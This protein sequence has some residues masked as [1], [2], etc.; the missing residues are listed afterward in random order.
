MAAL[1]P[2]EQ[3]AMAAAKNPNTKTDIGAQTGVDAGALDVK[4]GGALSGQAGGVPDYSYTEAI[5]KAQEKERQERE[6]AERNRQAEEERKRKEEEERKR[7]EEQARLEAQR[8]AY[9]A[10]TERRLAEATENKKK[11]EELLLK[12][13]EE[14]RKAAAEQQKKNGLFTVSDDEVTEEPDSD[15]AEAEARIY[16]E[17]FGGYE[18][19]PEDIK[20]KYKDYYGA[21]TGD[22]KIPTPQLSGEGAGV[23]QLPGGTISRMPTADPEGDDA[24]Y[25]PGGIGASIEVEKKAQ[26]LAEEDR[27]KKALK[28]KIYDIMKNLSNSSNVLLS[29]VGLGYTSIADLVKKNRASGKEDTDGMTA[30]QMGKY[31]EAAYDWYLKE[32]QAEASGQTKYPT[33]TGGSMPT[34]TQQTPTYTP[35][36]PEEVMKEIEEAKPEEQ[37]PMSTDTTGVADTGAMGGLVANYKTDATKA[38][39]EYKRKME[40]AQKKYASSYDE[41]V[42]KA[43]EQARKIASTEAS[44][45]QAQQQT[46]LRNVGQASSAAAILASQNVVNNFL[47]VFNQNYKEALS[48]QENRSVKEFET[49]IDKNIEVLKQNRDILNQEIEFNGKLVTIQSLL[50]ELE[51][52]RKQFAISMEQYQTAKTEAEKAEAWTMLQGW[53]SAIVEVWKAFNPS[54]NETGASN[55][56]EGATLIGEKGPE[57]VIVPEGTTVIPASATKEILKSDS[58]EKSVE[59][60]LSKH[61]LLDKSEFPVDNSI[62]KTIGMI[63]N[64]VKKNKPK[65]WASLKVCTPKEMDYK[66]KICK[67][68]ELLKR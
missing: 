12:Q 13:Q 21:Y 24:Y 43:T 37:K 45:A 19:L 68:D 61:T 14:T 54:R 62:M 39:E 22:H 27:K 50:T 15:L 57:V 11:Q 25:A 40:E 55:L 9:E 3:A 59:E 66:D 30:E 47:N 63:E 20:E 58:P 36:T 53:G 48:N 5:Q 49:E 44:L 34:D 51:I 7:Q 46:A 29:L 41:N 16:L 60:F 18:N 28:E 64:F 10:D 6:E 38:L 23:V 32:G 42:R 2:A 17:M 35:Q 33:Y 67:I 31:Y 52:K 56:P 4:T 1:T 26:E 8:A 65:D